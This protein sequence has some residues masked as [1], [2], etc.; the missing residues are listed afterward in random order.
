MN[1]LKFCVCAALAMAVTFAVSTSH[2]DP[3]KKPAAEAKKGAKKDGAKKGAKKEG[4]KK[5]RRNPGAQLAA[6]VMKR[7]AKVNLTEEQT[8][9]IKKLAEAHGAKMAEARKAAGLTKEQQQARQEAMKAAKADGKKGKEL[10]DAVAA[11]TKMSEEQKAAMA[12]AGAM[13]KE[14]MTAVQEVLTDEQKA[15]LKPARKPGNKKKKDAA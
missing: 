7:L 2:A 12:K 13:Q 15:A 3:A 1:V 11:A 9:K 6:G 14:F 4:A 10:R 5:G 8:A